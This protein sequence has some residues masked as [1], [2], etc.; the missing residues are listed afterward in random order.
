M[1][2]SIYRGNNYN[3]S[4][5]ITLFLCLWLMKQWFGGYH[6][7]LNRI[8]HYHDHA[9]ATHGKDYCKS[10]QCRTLIQNIPVFLTSSSPCECHSHVGLHTTVNL[11]S[12]Q[13]ILLNMIQYRQKQF[14]KQSL[15]LPTSVIKAS[16]SCKRVS[17]HPPTCYFGGRLFWP[18]LS[19]FG[20]VH[21]QFNYQN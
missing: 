15:N 6:L 9:V 12:A 11:I 19:L 13:H 4:A 10:S 20:T 17:G 8:C 1:W 2:C 7:S 16:V 5:V 18:L 21:A 14:V 3:C